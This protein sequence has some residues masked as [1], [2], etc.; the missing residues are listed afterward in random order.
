MFYSNESQWVSQ[1]AQ[2]QLKQ[3]ESNFHV[4]LLLSMERSTELPKSIYLKREHCSARITKIVSFHKT[5]EIIIFFHLNFIQI[6]VILGECLSF[7]IIIFPYTYKFHK[8]IIQ[9]LKLYFILQ[10]Y[11]YILV[12]K[13]FPFFLHFFFIKAVGYFRRKNINNFHD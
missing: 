3:L 11:T 2:K 9:I 4:V 10:S 5:L 1:G 8:T 6:S 12:P 13:L 7:P